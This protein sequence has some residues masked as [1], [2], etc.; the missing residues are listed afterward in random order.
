MSTPKH[1]HYALY[2]L[3]GPTPVQPNQALCRKTLTGILTRHKAKVTCVLC[4]KRLGRQ[5]Q[6]AARRCERQ[7][8]LAD[9]HWYV[10]T[11]RPR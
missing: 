6:E 8:A 5:R 3:T 1:C 10:R 4:L 2:P 7:W 9:A 11:R